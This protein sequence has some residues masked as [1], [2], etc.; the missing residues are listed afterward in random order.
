MKPIAYN[1]K[2]AFDMTLINDETKEVYE[3]KYIDMRLDM[4]TIPE[5][6]YGYNCRH[7]DD[8]DWVTPVMI[9]RGNVMVNFAGVFIVDQEIKFPEGKN[10]ICV[11]AKTERRKNMETINRATY[12]PPVDYDAYDE[13]ELD[14]Y[15]IGDNYGLEYGEE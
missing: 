15:Y 7:D 13:H 6:K 2:D 14:M 8:W 1:Q 10:Y 5:G 12:Y 9:E 11:S 4:S 3:G